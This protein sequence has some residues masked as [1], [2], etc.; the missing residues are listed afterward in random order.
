MQNVER[1]TGMGDIFAKNWPRLN[2]TIERCDLDV[3]GSGHANNK[4]KTFCNCNW[5][6]TF[7]V[8]LSMRPKCMKGWGQNQ[9]EDLGKSKAAIGND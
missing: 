2:L 4:N 8:S 3:S 6:E 1:S 9:T 5:G 7:F